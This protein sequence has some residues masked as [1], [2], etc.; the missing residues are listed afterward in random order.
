M[1]V[2]CPS[3]SRQE[4]TRSSRTTSRT[5]SQVG[6]RRSALDVWLTALPLPELEDSCKSELHPVP[7]LTITPDFA[8]AGVT[9][10]GGAT[11]PNGGHN[12]AVTAGAISYGVL[13]GF[14]GVALVALAA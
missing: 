3:C 13:V 2:S 1:T 14:V 5:S 11:S 9:P 10:T 12:A 4:R 7:S 6:L 8:A